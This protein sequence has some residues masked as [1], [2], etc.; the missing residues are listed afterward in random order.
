[1]SL[2]DTCG[3][4]VAD[5]WLYPQC[6]A[7]SCPQVFFCVRWKRV[8]Q[9]V[10]TFTACLKVV[11]EY[12]K[13]LQGMSFVPPFSFERG[14]YR[15]NGSPNRL[16]FTYLFCDK[17]HAIRFLQD[18]KLIRSQ[19]PTL[20]PPPPT[21]CQMIQEPAVVTCISGKTKLKYFAFL[22]H[23]TQPTF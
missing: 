2:T 5:Y 22:S 16:F 7:A 8:L 14:L 12:V 10:C 23:I 6:S 18:V 21:T 13:Q 4:A 9:R 19:V 11:G 15:D 17:A 3:A 20:L 1:M